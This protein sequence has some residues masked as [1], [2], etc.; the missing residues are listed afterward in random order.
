MNQNFDVVIVGGGAAGIMAGI[1]CIKTHPDYSVC[2][3]DRT[4]AIGRK[5]LVSGAGRCN[6]TN[7]NLATDPLKHYYGDK[8][9]IKGIFDQYPYE[10]IIEF[11]NELGIE[12][13]VEQKNNIGK[14]FPMTD[15]AKAVVTILEDELNR[16]GVKIFL[17]EACKSAQKVNTNEFELMTNINTFNCK[18]LI[19]STGGMTYPAL[20]SDGSGYNLA[21]SLG[22]KIINTIPAALPLTSK[23]KIC[24]H[25]QG[26]KMKIEASSYIN[27]Q[28]VKKYTDD[29]IFAQY[30]LSGMGIMNLSREI[31]IHYNRESGNNAYVLLN[32]FPG[33]SLEQIMMVLEKRW[34][35]RPTQSIEKSLL[36]LLPI[37]VPAFLLTSLNIPLETKVSKLS[38]KQKSD[39]YNYIFAYKVEISGTRGWNEA[40]F[41]AGGV[42]TGEVK[43]NSLES[44]L[45]DK[46]YLCGEILNVDG[47]I[48]GYNLSWAWGSGNIAG[49]LL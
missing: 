16:L 32:F 39:L 17:N 33:K 30:G 10:E 18:Y 43:D 19:L 26:I 9:F 38:D 11:F 23:D 7:V 1:S 31:S 37:K 28:F 35:A 21:K 20:G 25:L 12:T 2:I 44:K 41:T 15:Q 45:C 22:H 13:Y 42:D 8:D 5:I 27:N 29:V 4:C 34:N 36:G 6:I 49:K 40:E 3:I 14:V 24:H 47:D 48:G 46:L